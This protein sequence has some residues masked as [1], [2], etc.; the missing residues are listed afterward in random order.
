MNNFSQKAGFTLV[1]LLVYLASMIMVLAVLTYALINAYG[2]YAAVL[3][4]ARADRAAGTLMQILASEIRSGSS[5]NQADSVFNTPHGQLSILSRDNGVEVEKVFWVEDS[6]VVSSEDD[7]E[8]FRTPVDIEVSKFL[9]TQ[10]LTPV[11][12]AVRYEIDL[13][14]PVRGELVT[15][16]YPGVVILRNSYE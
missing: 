15:K 12:Y 13:T 7:V 11:S 16:T 9:F 6:R 8:T 1:E 4:E 3:V 10:I 2:F 14:F 5:I